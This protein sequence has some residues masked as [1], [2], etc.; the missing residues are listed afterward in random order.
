MIKRFI[1]NPLLWLGLGLG[2]TVGVLA[3]SGL[4]LSA[5]D[6]TRFVGALMGSLIAVGGAISLH[7]LKEKEDKTSRRRHLR[8]LI[9]QGRMYLIGITKEID[10]KNFPMVT[11]GLRVTSLYIDR[12][13]RYCQA[14]ESNDLTIASIGNLFDH[15]DPDSVKEFMNLDSKYSL[16]EL[17]LIRDAV[18][19]YMEYYDEALNQS[20][21]SL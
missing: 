7:F 15:L 19:T 11:A 20:Q 21:R 14:H 2:A 16:E 13:R 1:S 3:V 17:D 5:E 18:R 4:R 12:C 10:N 9:G 8:H 6:G